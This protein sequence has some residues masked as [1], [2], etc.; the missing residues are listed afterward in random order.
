MAKKEEKDRI[1]FLEKEQEDFHKRIAFLE[2]AVGRMG[3][4]LNNQAVI[5]KKIINRMGHNAN[6]PDQ[7]DTSGSE[8]QHEERHDNENGGGSEQ[9]A[10]L[11]T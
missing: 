1:A 9:P 6:Q 5:M 2:N 3:Q 4:S 10:L 7:P 11:P 8:I